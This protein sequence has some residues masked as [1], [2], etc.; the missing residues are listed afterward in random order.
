MSGYIDLHCH[1]VPGIDDGVASVEDG[2]AVLAGLYKL[3]YTKVAAT[4]HIR[5]GMFDNDPDALRRAFESFQTAASQTP[6]LP[7]LI[8]GCEHHVDSGFDALLEGG[9]LIPYTGEHAVLIELPPE[10]L[11][12]HLDRRIFA[13]R[14]KRLRPVIAHPERYSPFFDSSAKLETL[15]DLGAVALLDVMSLV[16]KYG[17]RPRKAAE[18]MLEEGVYDAACTDCH[19]V[20]DVAVCAEAIAA[21]RAIVGREEADFLLSEGPAQILAGTLET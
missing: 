13:L 12:L 11:P 10:Q 6:N 7:E 16:D 15:L 5:V 4:P 9:R 8:L 17:R 19:R 18:R 14:R 20:S 2:L 1:Y 3:G 21:L